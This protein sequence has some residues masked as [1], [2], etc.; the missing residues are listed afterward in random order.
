MNQ[1]KIYFYGS[2]ILWVRWGYI[3]K[4]TCWTDLRHVEFSWR[5]GWK[6]VSSISR[7]SENIASMRHVS[8]S[9]Y[10][11]G[12]DF[13]HSNIYFHLLKELFTYIINHHDFFFSFMEENGL[14]HIIYLFL[15]IWKKVMFTGIYI[16]LSLIL[17]INLESLSSFC[18]NMERKNIYILQNL[19]KDCMYT[20][21]VT[22]WQWIVL[23]T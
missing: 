8:F 16:S 12:N 3:S 10:L 22:F 13:F 7:R 1:T 2:K 11:K 23:R 21:I 14:Y 5:L 6:N 9:A 15:N 18:Y 20:L 4:K 19:T 17:R